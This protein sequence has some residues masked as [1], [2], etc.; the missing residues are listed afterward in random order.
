[1]LRENH[2]KVNVCQLQNNVFK[3]TSI[4]SIS[5]AVLRAQTRLLQCVFVTHTAA[6]AGSVDGA[7]SVA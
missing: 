4:I 3:T 7:Q 5:W 2:K 6:V 1:M